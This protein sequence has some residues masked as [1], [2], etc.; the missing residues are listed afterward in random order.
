MPATRF[1][2]FT[3]VFSIGL[4]MMNRPFPIVNKIYNIIHLLMI[5]P[6]ITSNNNANE[7][8]LYT[9]STSNITRCPRNY[10]H[11]ILNHKILNPHVL[12]LHHQIGQRYRRRYSH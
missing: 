9:V 2:P 4:N 12:G 6:D 11:T 5:I 7:N 1:V 8:V 3:K 10:L